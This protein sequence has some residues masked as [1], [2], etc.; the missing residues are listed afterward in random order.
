M[1]FGQ[2]LISWWKHFVLLN[3]YKY[4]ET[5]NPWRKIIVAKILGQENWKLK[6]ELRKLL[7]SSYLWDRVFLSLV[8]KGGFIQRITHLASKDHDCSLEKWL[9]LGLGQR[10]QKMSLEHLV[11]PC[12][13]DRRITTKKLP[14][15]KAGKICVK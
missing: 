4:N 11:V 9:V 10:K 3:K 7:C 1:L 6:T 15:A 14:I 12:Q 8:S 13:L 2:H 5:S